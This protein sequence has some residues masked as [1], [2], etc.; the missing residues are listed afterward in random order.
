MVSRDVTSRLILGLFVILV[1][2]VGKPAV[3]GAKPVVSR[4]VTSRLILGLFVI[5]VM[6]VGKPAVSGAKP[7][8]LED[9]EI[10]ELSAVFIVKSVLLTRVAAFCSK[11]GLLESNKSVFSEELP[12]MMGLCS[13][14]L[15]PPKAGCQLALLPLL[16]GIIPLSN[17]ESTL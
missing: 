15:Y 11:S 13:E 3:S 4:D 10:D 7:V 1:M 16:L 5:L 17:V 2:L 12:V 9:R 8:V 14:E 6:L